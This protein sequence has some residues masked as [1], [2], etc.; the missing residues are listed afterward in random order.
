MRLKRVDEQIL[1][2]KQPFLLC[3]P[4]AKVLPVSTELV[5]SFGQGGE[6]A[7]DEVAQRNMGSLDRGFE[8]GLDG[9]ACGQAVGTNHEN[10][11][12]GTCE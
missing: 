5:A 12:L 7:T 3:V 1:T 2:P 9:V 8:S 10:H 11:S 6:E 4:G